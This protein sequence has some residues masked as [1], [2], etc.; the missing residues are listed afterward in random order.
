[1]T[2]WHPFTVAS[3][4]SSPSTFVTIKSMGAGTWTQQLLQKVQ[5]CTR[6]AAPMPEVWIDGFYGTVPDICGAAVVILI[7]G[8]IGVTPFTSLL[9]EQL[10]RTRKNAPAAPGS[11]RLPHLYFVWSVRSL[12]LVQLYQPLLEEALSADATPSSPFLCKVD[13]RV[14]MT[15]TQHDAPSFVLHG[16]PDAP[17][18]FQAVAGRVAAGEFSAGEVLVLSCGPQELIDQSSELSFKH[19]FPFHKEEFYF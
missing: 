17:A 3:A 12:P 14:H 10:A 2:D 19:G 13:V 4:P 15:T 9:Q 8:G 16:R 5:Q 11:S 18:I 7:S 6:D 1:M